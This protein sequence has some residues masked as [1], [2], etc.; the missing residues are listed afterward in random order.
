M[1]H[2]LSALALHPFHMRDMLI[3]RRT[4]HVHVPVRFVLY[5]VLQG[6]SWDLEEGEA[7]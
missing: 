7:K 5:E 6:R 3:G 4:L 2:M 1:R